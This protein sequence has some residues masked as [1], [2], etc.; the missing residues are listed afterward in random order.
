MTSEDGSAPAS[1]AKDLRVVSEAQSDATHRVTVEVDAKRVDKVFDRVYREI[2]KTAS[3]RGF[4]RGKVPRSVLEKL[5]GAAI[6]EEAERLLL[7]ETLAEAIQLSELEPLVEPSIESDRPAPGEA[8][9]YTIGIEV[10]PPIEL[11]DLSKLTA[12]KPVVKVDDE[13]IDT[14]L[15][16]LRQQNAPLLEEPEGTRA[17]NGSV[18]NIDFVGRVEGETFEGGKG[19]D[20][21]IEL[22]SGRLVPGFEDQLIGAQS[23]DDVEV[24]LTFPEDYP[25]EE[26]AGKAAEFSVHVAAISR[27]EV[28]ELDDEFAKDLGDFDSLAA[29]R[30]RIRENMSGERERN[31]T[32]ALRDSL[33]DSLIE[34]TEF[35]VPPGIVD[36]QL[37]RQI[38]SMRHQFENQMPA[39]VLEQQLA[40]MQE[41]GRP[42]AERRV[43][44]GFLL[45][46]I[47]RS[48][49][50]AAADDEIDARLDEMAEAQGIPAPDL[51]KMAAEQ[52]WR[53][54][55]RAEIV[56][57][58]AVDFLASKATVEDLVEAE[59]S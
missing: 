14:E 5:Y 22:G 7:N 27:R 49:E 13:E 32:R 33:L 34:Q 48:N 39:D 15:E 24:A 35:R 17:Q 23:G 3:V 44:E 54:S 51:R 36:Q 47:I 2:G 37:Q 38:H 40:R 26:L 29:L 52:G 20:V 46:E 58:K 30:D 18:L 59:P 21:E 25:T 31:A 6:P 55:I 8:F 28:P 42:A 45:G 56:D 1:S 57:S 12:R 9:K 41:E 16:K 10:R 19:E 53:E 43:R 4:R 11:P 50:I